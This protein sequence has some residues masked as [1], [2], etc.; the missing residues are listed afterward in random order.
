M[1]D[2]PTGVLKYHCHDPESAVITDSTV[3]LHIDEHEWGVRELCTSTITAAS[4]FYSISLR[5]DIVSSVPCSLSTSAT[6]IDGKN[7]VVY[8]CYF[9]SRAAQKV[10]GITLRHL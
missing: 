5:G 6:Y 8:T 7:E 9:I 10:Q 1:D 4:R 2:S 3:M